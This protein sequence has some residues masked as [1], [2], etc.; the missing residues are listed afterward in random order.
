VTGQPAKVTSFFGWTDASLMTHFGKTPTVVFGPGGKG[1]HSRV[2]YVL[3]E[4]M[5]KCMLVYAATAMDI[6]G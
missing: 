2:E 1:A 5:H 6:C 3:T 4:D